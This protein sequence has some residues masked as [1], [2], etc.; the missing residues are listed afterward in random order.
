MFSITNT[1]VAGFVPRWAEFRGFSILFD[2]PGDCLTP[3]G[4]LLDLT[5]DVDGDPKLGFYGGLRDALARLNPD[6]LMTAYGFCP[7]PPPSYHVTAWDG[8]NQGNVSWVVSGQRPKLEAYLAALPDA[9]T[10]PHELTDLAL[11]SPLVCR[12][13]WDIGFRFDRIVIWDGSVLVARLAP[14]DAA[15]GTHERLVEERS[16]LNASF[17]AAFGVGNSDRFTPH[18]SLGYFANREGGQMA[19]PCLPEW[20][21]FFAERMQGLTLSLAHASLYGF[22]DMATF[23]TAAPPAPTP[24]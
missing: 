6:L 9:V 24:A 12:R 11:A 2:G 14:T 18:V 10:R 17:R 19:T 1:K 7:L 8:G 13:D 21:Q 5:C 16:R 4:G 23:F 22:T 3:R 20:D 15:V